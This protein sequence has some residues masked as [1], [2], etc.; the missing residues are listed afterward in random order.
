[1]RRLKA[2]LL[3][4][5]ITLGLSAPAAA[6][7]L[8]VAPVRLQ[9]PSK[10]AASKIA[11]R[12]TGE[13]TIDAQVRIFKWVQ[14]DGKDQLIETRDVVAS[15]PIARLEPNKGSVVRIV[16]TTKTAIEGEEAY[17]LLVDQIPPSANKPGMAINFVLRYS[18]PVFF[19]GAGS[20]D[21]RLSWFVDVNGGDVTLSVANLGNAHMRLSGLSLTTANGR[22]V[23]VKQGLVG[24][25]LAN[26]TARFPLEGTFKGLKPGQSVLITAEGNDGPLEATAEIRKAK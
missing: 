9:I 5:A 24:Y 26:S 1:M 8:Q 17:R 7:S 2:G 15:P 23:A 6:A 22:A 10:V 4:L 12:N 14:I 19:S 16:R 13:E 21:A 11:L 18:I 3:I 20:A 25:I